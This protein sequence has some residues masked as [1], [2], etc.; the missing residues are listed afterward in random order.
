MTPL[1]KVLRNQPYPC[2][3]LV[4]VPDALNDRLEKGML[5][6]YNI[7]KKIFDFPLVGQIGP[8]EELFA[9][10]DFVGYYSLEDFRDLVLAGKLPINC[11][12]CKGP[13]EDAGMVSFELEE[14]GTA[15]LD[16]AAGDAEMYVCEFCG[17]PFALMAAADKG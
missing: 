6:L 16:C 10:L 17:R 4:R 5:C 15:Q 14:T 13:V 3:R 8:A 11:P 2:F 1:E 7:D 12:S 9:Y